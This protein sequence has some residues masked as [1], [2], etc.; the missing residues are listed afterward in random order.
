MLGLEESQFRSLEA[1]IEPWRAVVN[2]HNG[3]LETQN[4]VFEG[5]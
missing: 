5:L 4:G 3:G 1:Q 2:A